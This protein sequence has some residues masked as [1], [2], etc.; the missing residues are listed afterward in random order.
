MEIVKLFLVQY[1]SWYILIFLFVNYAILKMQGLVPIVLLPSWKTH[2]YGNKRIIAGVFHYFS[3]LCAIVGILIV[4]ALIAVPAYAGKPFVMDVQSLE[5]MR[6]AEPSSYDYS[7]RICTV[8]V[9]NGCVDALLHENGGLYLMVIRRQDTLKGEHWTLERKEAY[10][11]DHAITYAVRE[12]QNSSDIFWFEYDGIENSP[13]ATVLLWTVLPCDQE[14]PD[15][16]TAFADFE[17]DGEMYRMY[18]SQR[19]G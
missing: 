4:V 12:Y 10:Y 18:F 2:D 11:L 8:E 7:Q 13:S 5:Q 15:S 19:K 6:E 14:M 3:L 17:L 16:Y 1:V 9:E